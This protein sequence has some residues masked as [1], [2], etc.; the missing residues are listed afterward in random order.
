KRRHLQ[1]LALA[2]LDRLREL[3]A[4]CLAEL[5]ERAADPIEVLL[6]L[7]LR[8][9]VAVEAG[10]AEHARIGVATA[11]E[12]QACGDECE[13]RSRRPASLRTD[14]VGAH[15]CFT[16]TGPGANSRSAAK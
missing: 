5:H 14:S 7:A 15:G 9:Q 13:Q 10:R 2:A 1:L 8:R 4:L 16:P 12:E 3:L 11:G 6:A